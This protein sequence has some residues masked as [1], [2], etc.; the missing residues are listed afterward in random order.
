MIIDKRKETTKFLENSTIDNACRFNGD[1]RCKKFFSLIDKNPNQSKL[2]NDLVNIMSGK[3]FQFRFD[4]RGIDKDKEKELSGFFG[5]ND[6][7]K[8]FESSFTSPVY[9]INNIINQKQELANVIG[10]EEEQISRMIS[11]TS[12]L[13]SRFFIW[14]DKEKTKKR[15]I[16][17]PNK[18]LKDI[19]KKILNNIIYKFHATKF[20]HGFIHN[21]SIVSCAKE[22]TGKKFVLKLDI[23]NFFPSITREMV[24]G[25]MYDDINAENIKYIVP[26]IEMCLLDGRL[27]Q[28]APTSPA[29]SN[30]VCRNLDL[31]LSGAIKCLGFEI[32][33]TRYADDLIFS[34]NDDKIY[35]IIPIIKKLVTKFG[36]IVNEKK[37]KVLKSHQRQTVT[38]LVVNCPGKTSVRRRTRM[39]LR[40]YMHQ[41]IIGKKPIENVNINKLRGD[42]N[43]IVM[44]NP[45]QG[46]WFKDKFDTIIEMYNNR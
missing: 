14:K 39:N 5:E 12:V 36:F 20:A 6:F 21:R 13:Y 46:K 32:L 29:I 16:E 23:K 24:Y 22:H 27:P 7:I 34:S 10:V 19:Q 33:Y 43:I 3:M 11:D 38:G 18:E 41:I 40:A 2:V 26:A 37:V 25:A 4:P 30:I 35:R 44:A 42:V 28:G 17:A 15:W 1:T 8:I 45:Q 31:L 9:M